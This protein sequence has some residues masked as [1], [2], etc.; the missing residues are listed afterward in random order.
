MKPKTSTHK[1]P[2][3]QPNSSPM[4]ART[5]IR[6]VPLCEDRIV[7]SGHGHKHACR[8]QHTATPRH[9]RQNNLTSLEFLILWHCMVWADRVKG[10]CAT[11]RVCCARSLS[12]ACTLSHIRVFPCFQHAVLRTLLEASVV[13]TVTLRSLVLPA[14]CRYSAT[15]EVQ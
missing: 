10:L 14:Q 7:A 1:T 5:W 4:C 2:H 15:V 13:A 11:L 6:R 12:S 3:N 8:S 9:D